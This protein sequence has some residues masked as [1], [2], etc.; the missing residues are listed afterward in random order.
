MDFI[1]QTGVISML[2]QATMVV[3]LVLAILAVMS[4]IS[5][6]LIF[7]KL[8]LLTRVRKNVREELQAF[9]NAKDLATAMQILKRRPNSRLYYIGY[10]AVAELKRLE[11]APLNPSLKVKVA[12][13]NLRRVLRQAVSTQLSNLSYALSF[14]ATCANAAPFIGLF[15]TV[16][17]IMHSFHSIGQQ[18]TAALA[19]VAPGISEALVATAIGLAVAIPATVAYNAFLG[20][21]SSIETE[22]VNCAGAFLNRSQRELP[23]LGA[24]KVKDESVQE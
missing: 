7:Y 24:G 8:F 18:K 15:G 22:L 23:W 17:G 13:D 12:T 14:L 11:K 21:L 9:Q 16:W 1:S 19:A 20:L 4:V 5:W 6:S 10:Q 3:K 2:G